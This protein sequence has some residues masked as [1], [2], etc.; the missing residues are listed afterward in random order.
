MGRVVRRIKKEEER[1]NWAKKLKKNSRV[2]ILWDVIF[3][4][5]YA[6][7]GIINI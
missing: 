3:L 5:N 1:V 4:E 7:N 6:F 2:K